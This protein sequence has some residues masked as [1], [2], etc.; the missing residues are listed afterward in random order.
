MERDRRIA[1]LA[2]RSEALIDR[3]AVL[4][5]HR[6]RAERALADGRHHLRLR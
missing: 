2:A 6:R 3:W 4:R 5:T 1:A